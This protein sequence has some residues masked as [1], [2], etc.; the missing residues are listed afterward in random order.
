[1]WTD[2]RV[3]Q[4]KVRQT[5]SAGNVVYVYSVIEKILDGGSPANTDIGVHGT[6]LTW[7]GAISDPKFFNG[8]FNKAAA[9]TLAGPAAVP[10]DA[11]GDNKV[12]VSDLGILAAN[13][14]ATSGAIWSTGDFN[15]DGKVDV[16]DL[17]ILAA[18]YGTGTGASLD[19]NADATAVGLSD[20]AK[21]ETLAASN[22]GCG[23]IGLPLVAGLMLMG[24]MLVKLEE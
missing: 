13:Y 23:S 6:N 7:D 1:L 20:E 17:G 11:N 3:G 14:G 5:L 10:G 8:A 12:D 15:N 18:N 9:L 19:F 22:L 21:E 24:V 16:S 2:W 4:P